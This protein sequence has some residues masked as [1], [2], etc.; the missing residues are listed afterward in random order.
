MAKKR[1]AISPIHSMQS[2]NLTAE[3]AEDA[4]NGKHQILCALRVL[5]G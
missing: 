2:S 3:S 5:C 1:L 4:E